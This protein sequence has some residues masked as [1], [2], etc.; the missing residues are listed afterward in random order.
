[1]TPLVLAGRPLDRAAEH[2]RRYCGLPWSGGPP[3]VWA[4]SYYDALPNED[5]L[6][7]TPVDVVAAAALHPKLTR[8]DLIWFATHREGLR[9]FLKSAPH[10]DLADTDPSLLDE[11]PVLAAADVEL[12]LL[13]KV[14]HRKRPGLIPLLDRSLLD[15][16]RFRLGRRGAAAWSELVR[17]LAEDLRHNQEQLAELGAMVPLTDLRIADVAIWMEIRT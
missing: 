5:P 8:P 14:L 4:Y 6:D 10:S 13:T 11:L 1:M 9:R 15:W 2:V 3:E 17:A 7:V 16:Y 12:S